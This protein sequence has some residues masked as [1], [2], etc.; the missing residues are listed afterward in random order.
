MTMKC[1][2]NNI[3]LYVRHCCVSIATMVMRKRHD[4]TLHAYCLIY[5]PLSLCGERK[6]QAYLVTRT[7]NSVSQCWQLLHIAVSPFAGLFK[8]VL[9]AKSEGFL[10]ALNRIHTAGHYIADVSWQPF[11]RSRNSLPLV[12]P[13]INYY[14]HNRWNAA[15]SGI[16]NSIQFK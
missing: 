11:R 2:S 1:S 12:K 9:L 15:L 8:N 3:C 10:Q 6:I 13:K 4:V 16:N 14:V 7:G 5:S